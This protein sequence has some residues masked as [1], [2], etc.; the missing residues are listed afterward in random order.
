MMPPN[1]S[2]PSEVRQSQVPTPIGVVI[3]YESREA[4]LRA[5][6]ALYHVAESLHA[7]F[8]F[9]TG[10]WSFGMF[11]VPQ[12]RDVVMRDAEKA[13]L[14]VIA[15]EAEA[16]IPPE[17]LSGITTW[18]GLKGGSPVALAL[19]ANSP[20]NE[21]AG[22]QRIRSQMELIA[23]KNS[24]QIL[25]GDLRTHGEKFARE[26]RGFREINRLP[27]GAVASHSEPPPF[28]EGWGIND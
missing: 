23:K 16:A 25:L 10:V 24:I 18:C 15:V 19:L 27:P 2:I 9:E 11:R 6:G 26:I 20:E 12:L 7:E 4:A 1:E 22:L 17:V 8:A 5:T 28:D 14:V 3:I 21:N 13:D